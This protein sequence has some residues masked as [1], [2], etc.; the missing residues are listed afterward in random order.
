MICPI[1][2]NLLWMEPFLLGAEAGRP[3]CLVVNCNANRGTLS[4]LCPPIE[5]R[6]MEIFRGWAFIRLWQTDGSHP[7]ERRARTHPH[8]LRGRE[9]C[10]QDLFRAGL[11]NHMQY[12]TELATEGWVWQHFLKITELICMCCQPWQLHLY[13]CW[14]TSLTSPLCQRLTVG[15]QF[16]SQKAKLKYREDLLTLGLFK[17]MWIKCE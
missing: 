1:G 13:I 16:V 9:A 10:L 8:Q 6:L 4:G 3:W 7:D 11:N 2:P 5:A 17:K 15:C 14:C 12:A